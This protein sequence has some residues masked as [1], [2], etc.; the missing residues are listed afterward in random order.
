MKKTDRKRNAGYIAVGK[1][2]T[3]GKANKKEKTTVGCRMK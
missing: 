3:K 2:H 1:G